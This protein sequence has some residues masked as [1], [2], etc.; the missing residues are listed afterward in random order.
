MR[1]LGFKPVKVFVIEKVRSKAKLG[2][3]DCDGES[4]NCINMST[5]QESMIQSQTNL[6]TA[7]LF[8]LAKNISSAL[9]FALELTLKNFSKML[10][11]KAF[12]ITHIVYKIGGTKVIC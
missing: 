5:A 2:E 1:D 4:K 7:F 12:L 8:T 11:K 6:S 10:L 9:V 3:R